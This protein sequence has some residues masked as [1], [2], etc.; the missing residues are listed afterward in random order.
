MMLIPFIWYSTM[1]LDQHWFVDGL[2]GMMLAV[3]VELLTH[4][5]MK[6]PD[7]AQV[8]MDRRAHIAWIGPYVL[9]L[10]VVGAVWLLRG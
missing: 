6:I 2:V 5:W 7:E 8:A 10:L 1:A 9:V 4:R 3:T